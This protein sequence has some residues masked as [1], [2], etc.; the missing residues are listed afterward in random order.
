SDAAADLQKIA[1]TFDI[2]VAT[3]FRAKGV[4]PEDH[5]LSLGIFG[6][7]GHPPAEDGLTSA[8]LDVLL[9]LGSSLNQRDT[10][11][12]NARRK[13]RLGVASVYLSAAELG[14]NF[15][16]RHTIMGDVRTALRAL[17]DGPWA[18]PLRRTASA[19][20]AWADTFLRRPRFLDADTL[21]SDA[22]PVHPARIVAEL[23]KALP[24]DLALLI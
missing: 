9:V 2:P 21:G 3:T 24:R 23:R 5:P 20:R 4:L 19:R 1:E 8:D 22:V 14:R 13:P 18:E 6:Y 10:L 7:A 16:V 15:P 17:L 12:W 11:A